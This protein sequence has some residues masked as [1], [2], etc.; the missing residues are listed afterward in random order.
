MG[1]EASILKE[2][3][4]LGMTV[5]ELS[6]IRQLVKT[7]I[8]NPAFLTPFDTLVDELGKCYDV[9]LGVFEPLVALDTE[10]AFLDAFDSR[11]EA[12]RASYLTQASKPRPCAEN[13]F[14]AYLILKTLKESRTGYPILR[15]TFARLDELVDK[16]VTNDAW[17]VMHLDG[18]LKMLNRLLIEVAELKQRDPE[19][20]W[21]VFGPAFA[22]FSRYL[23]LIRDARGALRG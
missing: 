5:T 7:H 21:L 2:L 10:A 16:W 3:G 13:A 12:F 22:G 1:V 4:N 15:R 9:L 11:H 20:A 8:H 23:V 14:E 17:L 19:D 18:A 6:A